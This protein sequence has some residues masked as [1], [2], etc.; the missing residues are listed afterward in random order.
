L[1]LLRLF[2]AKLPGRICRGSL[3]AKER[4]DR[5]DSIRSAE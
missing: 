2:A 4:K 1:R 3:A 5:K